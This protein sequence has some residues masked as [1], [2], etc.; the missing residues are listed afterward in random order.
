MGFSMA[1][2]RCV[3][4]EE[5]KY[6]LEE[7]HEGVCRDHIGLRSLVSKIIKTGYYWPTMQKEAK[8]YVE[9]CD[10]CQRFGNVQRIPR[11]RMMAIT[12]LEVWKHSSSS[13]VMTLLV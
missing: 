5:A 9:K 7:V 8:E 2:L 10:K 6:I 1:Y 12:S 11:E 4:E 13:H 3:E